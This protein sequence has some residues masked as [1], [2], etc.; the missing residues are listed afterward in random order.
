[1]F[2][3]YVAIPNLDSSEAMVPVLLLQATELIKLFVLD[4]KPLW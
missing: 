1:M 4:A 2:G 3:L